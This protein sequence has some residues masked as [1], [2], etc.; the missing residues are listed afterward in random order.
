VIRVTVLSLFAVI[1]W[2]TGVAAQVVQIESKRIR[3]D[4]TGWAG[5]VAA[6]IQLIHSTSD[7]I[8]IG[9]NLHLQYK[10][11]RSL[12]LILNNLD[13]I[14]ADRENFENRGYEHFRY[15]YKVRDWLTWEAFAQAQYNKPLR[16]DFRGL[17]GT[18]PRF[19]VF[20]TKQ[21]RAYVASLVMIERENITG[22]PSVNRDVR[23]GSYVSFTVEPNPKVRLVSTTYYQP[24]VRAPSDYRLASDST[25]SAG[26]TQKLAVFASFSVLYDTRPPLGVVSSSYTFKN[27]IVYGF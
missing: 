1:L 10:T 26:V 19:K 21:A 27:G 11:T 16:L 18:G 5:E 3:T 24:N 20:V 2:T 4:T 8:D 15:N 13:F 25:F 14:R 17:V 12:Y 6:S 22:S 7:V 9:T 23:L